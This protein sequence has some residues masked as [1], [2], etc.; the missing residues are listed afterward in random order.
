MKRALA[1]GMLAAIALATGVAAEEPSAV[2][3]LGASLTPELVVPLGADAG[4]FSSGARASLSAYAALP[5][6]H[7]LQATTELHYAWLPV[8]AASQVNLIGVG[9]G[10]LVSVGVLPRLSA[11]VGGGAGW[12][13]AG[14]SS[15]AF[16]GSGVIWGDYPFVTGRLGATFQ[17]SPSLRIGLGVSCTAYLGL[18][19]T[20]GVALEGTFDIG[21]LWQQPLAIESVSVD[22]LFPALYLVYAREP[23][24]TVRVRNAGRFPVTDVEAGILIDPYMSRAARTKVADAIEPGGIREVKLGMTFTDRILGVIEGT[25]FPAL[26][27][28]GYS[29]GGRPRERSETIAVGIRGRNSLTWEDSRRA[30]LFV[31]EKDPAVLQFA[32]SVVSAVRASSRQ[33]LTFAFRAA[34]AVHAALREVGMSYVVDPASPY[35]ALAQN[36]N[37]VDFL[38]FPRQTLAARAGDCD[39]LTVLYCALLE[40][41]GVE[42][43]FVTVPGHIMP[44]VCLDLA[45]EVARRLFSNLDNLIVDDTRVWLPVEITALSG[46]F[47]ASWETAAEQWRKAGAAGNAELLPVRECWK[48]YPPVS[49]APGAEAVPYPSE[50]GVARRYD[51]DMSS[52]VNREID[53]L[54]ASRERAAEVGKSSLARRNEIGVLYARYGLL[55]KAEAVFRDVLAEETYVPALVNLGT[56]AWL[57]GQ[58]RESLELFARAQEEGGTSW[59]ILLGLARACRE[60]GLEDE[61]LRYYAQLKGTNPEVAARYAYLATGASSEVRGSGPSVERE[62]V[63]WDE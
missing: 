21:S 7:W 23:P 37:A 62:E 6:L 61:A 25:S 29:Y 24:A 41:M 4:L 1:L 30:A 20:V 54:V 55:E 16:L 59:T 31:S 33:P 17:I 51:E 8:R 39:D 63:E 47:V 45:P 48:S 3:E 32:G 13:F 2:A 42:T 5:R 50:Y 27:T 60:L 46:S 58:A 26:L 57:R 40:S 9:A 14:L 15:A 28:I 56:I 53:A 43:A 19:T 11:W 10:A 36:R 34:A 12:S 52:F 18:L 49:L 38:K 35:A 22:P 44:A